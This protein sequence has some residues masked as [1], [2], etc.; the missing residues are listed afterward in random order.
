MAKIQK[1]IRLGRGAKGEYYFAYNAKSLTFPRNLFHSPKLR[2]TK[3]LAS[4]LP[5]GASVLDAGC[6]AGY[7]SQGLSTK[8]KLTGVDI[9]KEAIE[10]CK[11]TRRGR[12][13][14]AD[15]AS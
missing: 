4:Q 11:V 13:L 12:F 15:L 7:V 1:K 3:E 8:L 5:D 14:R 9:E 2:I 6:G 10:F